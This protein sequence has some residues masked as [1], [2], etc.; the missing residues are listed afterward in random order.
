[1]WR[2]TFLPETIFSR[3]I[4]L[5]QTDSACWTIQI[6]LDEHNWAR[7]RIFHEVNLLSLVSL[8]KI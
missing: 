3:S 7:R 5:K 1:M 6:H 4:R 2:T 8:M